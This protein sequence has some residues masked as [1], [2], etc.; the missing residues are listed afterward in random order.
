MRG[1]FA[2]ILERAHHPHRGLDRIAR[3]VDPVEGLF[4]GHPGPGHPECDRLVELQCQV[5][6]GARGGMRN[7]LVV[8]IA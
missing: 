8:T 7:D 4:A 2:D 1:L 5:G 6:G 3:V